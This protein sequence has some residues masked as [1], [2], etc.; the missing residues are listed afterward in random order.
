MKIFPVHQANVNNN[1]I[2]NNVFPLSNSL[3]IVFHLYI[4][5]TIPNTQPLMKL[6]ILNNYMYPM[7]TLPLNK[8][9]QYPNIISKYLFFNVSSCTIM[10]YATTIYNKV[11]KIKCKN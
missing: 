3:K 6:Q 8:Q 1:F 7:A 2:S 5:A 10:L 11:Y 4:G 9:G